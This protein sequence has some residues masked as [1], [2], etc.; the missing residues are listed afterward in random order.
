MTPPRRPTSTAPSAVALALILGISSASCGSTGR[1]ARAPLGDEAERQGHELEQRPIER[2][3]ASA[4][5][6]PLSAAAARPERRGGRGASGHQRRA[7]RRL[8]E[9]ERG[10]AGAA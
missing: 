8:T 9:R 6:R 7:E 2:A 5:P 1:R 3:A 4:A 10:V